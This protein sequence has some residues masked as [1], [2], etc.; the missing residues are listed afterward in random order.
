MQRL[1]AG[2]SLLGIFAAMQGFVP[3]FDRDVGF[4][5]RR[6]DAHRPRSDPVAR[7]EHAAEAIVV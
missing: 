4:R 6:R 3:G 5:Q 7:R 1:I 2:A